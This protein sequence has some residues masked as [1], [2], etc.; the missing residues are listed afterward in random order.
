MNFLSSHL[1]RFSLLIISLS[2]NAGFVTLLAAYPSIS[3]NYLIIA[4]M[5]VMIAKSYYSLGKQAVTVQ[6]K[7]IIQHPKRGVVIS[8]KDLWQP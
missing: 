5:V 3:P 2:E 1:Q 7:S 8:G 6:E 4:H